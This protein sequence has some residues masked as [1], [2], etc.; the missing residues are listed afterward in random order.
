MKGLLRKVVLSRALVSLSLRVA[1]SGFGFCISLALAR[2]MTLSDFGHYSFMYSW[3]SILLIIASFGLP[4]IITR[5]IPELLVSQNLSRV[6]PFFKDSQR[7]L[8]MTSSVIFVLSVVAY[9]F[10]SPEHQKASLLTIFL[11]FLLVPLLSYIRVQAALLHGH[12]KTLAGQVPEFVLRPGLYLTLLLLFYFSGS[13]IEPTSAFLFFTISCFVTIVCT[14]F[15]SFFA[16]K[17]TRKAKRTSPQSQPSELGLLL[18]TGLFVSLASVMMYLNQNL[19]LL[20]LGYFQEAD[21]VGLYIPI[22]RLSFLTGIVVQ[23]LVLVVR[24]KFSEYLHSQQMEDLQQLLFKLSRSSFVAA[25]FLAGVLIIFPEFL[26]SLYGQNFLEGKFALQ[27]MAAFWLLTAP[28]GGMLTF[29]L[30]TNQEKFCI[31]ISA[32]SIL[33]N[34]AIGFTLIPDLGLLGAVIATSAARTFWHIVSF[35]HVYKTMKLRFFLF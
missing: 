32:I 9:P 7:I 22:V 29:M 18:R 31:R 34:L 12:H 8:A 6:W 28:F 35:W 21:T 27:L 13:R 15:Y 1:S 11:C 20:M 25:L 19:D 24:P 23:S 10:L 26:L 17:Q 30:M 16:L 2:L 4:Q 3:V 33:I 14:A 5:K